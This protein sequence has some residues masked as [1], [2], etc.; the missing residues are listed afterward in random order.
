MGAY[1]ASKRALEAWSE[2][3]RHELRPLGV[4]VVCL[5]PGTYRTGVAR[6]LRL[7]PPSRPSQ[8]PR[9]DAFA[10]LVERSL[11]RAADPQE[12]GDAV[13]ALLTRPPSTWRRG[14]GP[15]SWALPWLL[16]LP[17][18][19]RDALIDRVLTLYTPARTS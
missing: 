5:R 10:A 1:A 17:G 12:V 4:G 6:R 3:L 14:I 11:D 16:R 7:L 19:W 2:S 8:Q 18:V 13:L 15:G 9:F